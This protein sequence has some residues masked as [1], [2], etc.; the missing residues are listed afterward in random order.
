[1]KKKNPVQMEF[2]SSWYPAEW[3]I[4]LKYGMASL[5]PESAFFIQ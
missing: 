1:M 4:F 5:N 2:D 3:G